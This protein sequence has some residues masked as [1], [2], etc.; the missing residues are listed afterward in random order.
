M[1]GTEGATPLPIP[2]TRACFD[3]ARK[4]LLRHGI[5]VQEVYGVDPDSILF[6]DTAGQARTAWLTIQPNVTGA[7]GVP[8]TL[9]HV[10]VEPGFVA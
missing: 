7:Y 8:Q 6:K 3:N 1:P 10:T 2:G 5:D 9:I 4:L